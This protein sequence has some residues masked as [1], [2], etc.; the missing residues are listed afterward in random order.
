MRAARPSILLG[1]ILVGLAGCSG[2]SVDRVGG[3]GVETG[4]LTVMVSDAGG[5]MLVGARVWLLDDAGDSSE[6]VP[7]DSAST[8]AGGSAR[9]DLDDPDIGVEAWSGDTLAAL[10]RGRFRLPGDTVA[11]LLERPIP[12]ALDC[13]TFSGMEIRQ[14]GSRRSQRAPASCVDSFVVQVVAPARLL[15]AV[16]LTGPKRP[17]III[18][19]SARYGSG[20]KGFGARE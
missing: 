11:L 17:I 15:R 5:T 9:F 3:G 13:R 19:D 6:A 7:L 8:L 16:P 14:P 2:D 18:L 10:D 12:L 4:D 1:A 20:R